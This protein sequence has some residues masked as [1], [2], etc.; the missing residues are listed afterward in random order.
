MEQRNKQPIF[1]AFPSELLTYKHESNILHETMSC[2]HRTRLA[3][4]DGAHKAAHRNRWVWVPKRKQLDDHRE[5]IFSGGD[6]YSKLQVTGIIS[7][8]VK[9]GKSGSESS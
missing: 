8:P 1:P 3:F 6:L 4:A 2:M 9:Q 5:L 7:H